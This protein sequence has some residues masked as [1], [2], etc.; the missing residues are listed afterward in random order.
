MISDFIIILF[1][2]IGSVICHEVAHGW[3]A[4][5]LGDPTAKLLGRLTFNPLK[6][7][8]PWGSLVIPMILR[9]LGFLPIGW[10]KPVPV[11][12]NNLKNP[13]RDMILVAM[14]GPIVNIF[15][16]IILSFFLR[17]LKMTF[18]NEILMLGISI[19]L[20]LAIFN[21]IPIPPLDGSRLILGLLPNP[22]MRVYSQLEPFGLLIVLVLL[23]FGLLNF[24][25]MI[26]NSV[27]NLLIGQG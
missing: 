8:D 2:L 20:V 12:F 18:L 11:N 13:K 23:N 24:V 7:I 3:V 4:Y 17:F 25:W 16:A 27:M 10:A 21:L 6:H 19:N 9:M 26:V 14:A 5:W 15:L 22:A 1:F